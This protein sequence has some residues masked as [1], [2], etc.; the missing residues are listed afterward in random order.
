MCNSHNTLNSIQPSSLSL[1]NINLWKFYQRLY[2]KIDLK[3]NMISWFSYKVVIQ[4]HFQTSSVIYFFFVRKFG[5]NI[6]FPFLCN[7]FICQTRLDFLGFA[8]VIKA[9]VIFEFLWHRER[10]FYQH[11]TI[12]NFLD[13]LLYEYSQSCRTY[14]SFGS[15]E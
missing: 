12:K 15:R 9:T 4:W 10:K 6:P 5:W 14:D 2:R 3:N 1:R 7:V 8:N 11:W 13:F